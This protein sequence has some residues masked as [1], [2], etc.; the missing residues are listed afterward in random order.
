MNAA[1]EFP[2]GSDAWL[3]VK[4]GQLGGSRIWEATHKIK[5]GAY[6]A[7]RKNLMIVMAAERIT[8]RAHETYVTPAM[9][10]GI[11]FEP[12]AI[13]AY[14]WITGSS[15][16]P[17][18]WVQHP[19]IDWAGATPDGAV[20]DKGLIQVKCPTSAT[21]LETLTTKD[22]V[23]MYYAQCQWEIAVTG[24]DWNDFTSYDPRMPKKLQTCILRV[25]RDD[26]YIAEIEAEATKFLDELFDLVDRVSNA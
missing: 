10:H 23:P 18:G 24:R 22:V 1:V 21:H 20:G 3:V 15:V 12:E 26:K 7:D 16:A 2:Q 4:R 11:D 5:S 6:S 14:E 8:D 25:M 9:Q 13:A 17:V 19:T